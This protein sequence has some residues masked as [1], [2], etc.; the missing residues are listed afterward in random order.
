MKQ[1]KIIDTPTVNDDGSI[2]FTMTDG[3]ND[4]KVYAV[5]TEGTGYKIK[6]YEV[7]L[8]GVNKNEESRQ[9]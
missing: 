2:S 8:R 3:H 9:T 4:I 5:Y 6:D 7:L 1:V